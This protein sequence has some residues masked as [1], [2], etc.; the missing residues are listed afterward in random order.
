[1]Q[2]GVSLAVITSIEVRVFTKAGELSVGAHHVFTIPAGNPPI[3]IRD[4]SQYR[5]CD[6]WNCRH[7]I[8][9]YSYNRDTYW[10]TISCWDKIKFKND[11]D[12]Q[13]LSKQYSSS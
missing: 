13:Y 6:H 10:K 4:F 7:W 1:V 9:H 8:R 2:G 12:S 11:D 3:N 5:F